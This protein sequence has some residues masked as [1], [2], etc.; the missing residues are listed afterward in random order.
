MIKHSRVARASSLRVT[1]FADVRRASVSKSE[2]V[3][4]LLCHTDVFK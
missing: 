2:M 4:E 1:E 3:S